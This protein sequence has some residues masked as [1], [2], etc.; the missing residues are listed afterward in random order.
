MKVEL[1]KHEDE[2]NVRADGERGVR[3]DPQFPG[4]KKR[5]Y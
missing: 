4:L 5:T 1:A 3:N 2:L